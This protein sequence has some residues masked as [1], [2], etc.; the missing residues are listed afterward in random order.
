MVIVSGFCEL[1]GDKNCDPIAE[2]SELFFSDSDSRLKNLEDSLEAG[3]KSEMKK[4]VHALKGSASN[5]G[6]LRLANE[7]LQFEQL[8]EEE[9]D[10]QQLEQQLVAI[11]NAYEKVRKKIES[12]QKK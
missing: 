11:K 2:L 1:G 10:V 7:C 3:N 8:L 6:A 9:E 5:F 12:I 4:I